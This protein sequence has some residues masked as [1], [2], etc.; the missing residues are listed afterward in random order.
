[1]EIIGYADGFGTFTTGGSNGNMLGM[2]CARQS[3]YPSS[4]NGG[5]D[6]T[7]HVAF[8]SAEAHY[9]VLMSA[10]VI[11]IGHQN[12]IKVACDSHGRMKPNALIDE[13]QR[14]RQNDFIP[15][16]V[17]ATSGT[18]IGRASCRERV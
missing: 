13:I 16:C 18:K 10:N 11:G 4:S 2:L 7:K 8:V 1:M 5:F 17:I 9:S 12:L 3:L 14:A 15:F 6:G